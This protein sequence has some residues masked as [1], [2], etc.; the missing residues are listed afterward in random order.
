MK[1]TKSL[2]N[3]Q[4]RINVGLTIDFDRNSLEFWGDPSCSLEATY[5]S[6]AAMNEAYQQHIAPYIAEKK[7]YDMG[8][9]QN[10]EVINDLSAYH[11][12]LV[13]QYHG[14]PIPSKASKETKA[15]ISFTNQLR[16][17]IN[18]I[19]GTKTIT[20]HS[21]GFMIDDAGISG[22]TINSPL[23]VGKKTE[24]EIR[25]VLTTSKYGLWEGEFYENGAYSWEMQET[26]LEE[27]CD[28]GDINNLA[29]SLFERCV[30]LACARIEANPHLRPN[31]ST[32][33]PCFVFHARHDEYSI[34]WDWRE[35]ARAFV[36]QPMEAYLEAVE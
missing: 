17:R 29:S 34:D 18:K 2:M 20:L 28:Y 8:E 10:F 14:E 22:I 33:K 7:C 24:A 11:D 25:Q 9:S 30:Y 1:I 21:I 36:N 16:Q 3:A 35:T 15:I 27:L 31:I 32:T 23:L 12:E 4:D 26:G 13:I 19:V 6:M 5:K